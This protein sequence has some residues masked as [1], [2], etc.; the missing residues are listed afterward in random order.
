MVPFVYLRCLLNKINHVL[1][2]CCRS[3]QI[4]SVSTNGRG[5]GLLDLFLFFFFGIFM[6]LVS[7]VTDV[8]WFVK[9]LY[10]WK[11]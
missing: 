11:V 7:Q 10:Q 8:Y 9:H 4:T 6:L 1:C 2:C 3:K 5:P